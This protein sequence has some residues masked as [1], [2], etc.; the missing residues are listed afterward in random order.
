MRPGSAEPFQA[1][2]SADQK[3]LGISIPGV[4]LC[5]DPHKQTLDK[6]Y[7]AWIRYSHSVPSIFELVVARCCVG[8]CLSSM[9]SPWMHFVRNVRR[10]R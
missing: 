3:M 5:L 1:L 10:V 4:W 8:E 6:L 7:G 9:F 2:G